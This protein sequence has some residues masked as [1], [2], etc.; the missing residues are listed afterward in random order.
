MTTQYGKNTWKIRTQ[1]FDITTI[2]TGVCHKECVFFS[3]ESR[4]NLVMRWTLALLHIVIISDIIIIL[5][6]V[7]LLA[8]VESQTEI[9]SVYF[10]YKCLKTVFLEC[11]S[12]DFFFHFSNT[13][14]CCSTVVFCSFCQ[15]FDNMN[16]T[17]ICSTFWLWTV[18]FRLIPANIS[19]LALHAM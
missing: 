9:G 8:M 3:K 10:L 13:E 17:K 19:I 6:I 15:G 7:I 5:H 1:T 4:V 18:S 11:A 16:W 14:Y 12:N 2:S